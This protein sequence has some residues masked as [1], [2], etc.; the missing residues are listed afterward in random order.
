MKAYFITATD[1][2]AG[3]TFVS[4]GLLH[5]WSKQGFKTLGFKP[6]ASGCQMTHSSAGG[7]EGNGLRNEDALALIDAAN[8][9]LPYK[10]IN[11]YSFE[12]AI[13]PHIAAQQADTVIDLESIVATIRPY[14]SQ[15][16]YLIVEGVGGWQVPLNEQQNVSDLAKMLNFP[17]I[18][19][20]NLK[21]GC[22]NHALL[23]AQA[24]ERQGLQL[25]GWIINHAT[26]DKPM[27]HQAEN[28]QSLQARIHAPLLGELPYI[29]GS[30]QAQQEKFADFIDLE[31]CI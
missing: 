14:Q 29:S 16:D 1:T 25:A 18:L 26:N 31:K 22:I 24:I 15:V 8:V 7:E 19:V 13:A 27:S 11:P 4:A 20:V 23:T 30:V 2:D 12:P 9:S 28:V 10:T 5:S 17:V 21:L 6:I 3:K